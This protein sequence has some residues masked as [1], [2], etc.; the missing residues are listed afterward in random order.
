MFQLN[1][2]EA[3]LLL[4]LYLKP[5]LFLSL[6]DASKL[7]FIIKGVIAQLPSGSPD[8]ALIISRA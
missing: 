3:E 7:Q 5:G 8:F 4:K 6:Q 2:D 1:P